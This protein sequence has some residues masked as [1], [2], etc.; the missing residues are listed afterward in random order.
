MHGTIV[1]DDSLHKKVGLKHKYLYEN[2]SYIPPD[3]AFTEHNALVRLVLYAGNML[4]P[5][6][7]MTHPYYTI[8]L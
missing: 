4:Y 8:K 5:T 2:I 3:S 1:C 6:R 7:S